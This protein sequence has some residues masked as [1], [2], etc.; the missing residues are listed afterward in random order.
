MKSVL[1]TCALFLVLPWKLTGETAVSP[2]STSYETTTRGR[3]PI[4]TEDQKLSGKTTNS[5]SSTRI[6][7]NTS[8][9]QETTTRGDE[10]TTF[11]TKNNKDPLKPNGETTHS[12][13]NTGLHQSTSKDQVTTRRGEEPTTFFTQNRDEPTTNKSKNVSYSKSPP[14][15]SEHQHV[16]S[17]SHVEHLT[18][19]ISTGENNS[20]SHQFSSPFI[21]DVTQKQSE[22]I[23]TTPLPHNKSEEVIATK[24][25]QTLHTFISTNKGLDRHTH[26]KKTTR[27]AEEE[28]IKPQTDIS[29]NF[30]KTPEV[31][32]NQSVQ[33]TET[34]TTKW[35]SLPQEKEST[36]P[37][38]LNIT[39]SNG[40]LNI[41]NE[42]R[43][44]TATYPFTT[45]ITTRF[46]TGLSLTVSTE[47]GTTSTTETKDAKATYETTKA[48]I[49]NGT[50]PKPYRETTPTTQTD[51][52]KTI[53]KSLN[54]DNDNR[55]PGLIVA[56]LIGSI[57]LL[58]CIAFVVVFVRNH[59]KKKKQMEN[60]D[61]AG[62]SPFIEADSLPNLPTINEDGS[63]RRR[64]YK[65]ISLHSF[66]PQ[67]LSKRFSML[68]PTDEEIPLENTQVS[69]TFGQNNVQPLNG[70]ASLDEVQTHEANSPPAELSSN[71][72]VPETE[73]IPQAPENN[74]NVQTAT[75]LDDEITPSPPAETNSATPTPFEEVD[76]NL[77]HDKNT[78]TTSPSD[79]INIPSPPPLPP[80]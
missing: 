11:L 77:S 30:Q 20:S 23:T 18:H 19:A 2:I 59:Q 5:Q 47:V 29:T 70:K 12:P 24:D 44:D 26:G 10:P 53:P 7:K 58:M 49:R 27:S 6:K 32:T 1:I 52:T 80:S 40:T 45:S 13:N 3:E 61:W 22:I 66:L 17:M 9:D 51:S 8:K 64:E 69:S 62:P 54:K 16:T 37:P 33:T 60:S 71:S 56:S 65:R 63:F 68:S 67:Q 55:H 34:L 78:E 35:S 4:N 31:I 57:L 39:D 41:S 79:A 42:E 73:S 76:L 28:S 50:Q 14:Q 46:S 36:L 21:K 25:D 75:K 48:T 15:T 74:E 43:N 38:I 72:D